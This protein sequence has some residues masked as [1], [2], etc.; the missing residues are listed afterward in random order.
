MTATEDAQQ[1]ARAR[2]ITAMKKL[3]VFSRVDDGGCILA[4]DGKQEYEVI[5]DLNRLLSK[6]VDGYQSRRIVVGTSP[7]SPWIGQMRY[8]QLSP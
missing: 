7:P 3:G 8:V 5:V 2:L 1:S 4:F 6:R